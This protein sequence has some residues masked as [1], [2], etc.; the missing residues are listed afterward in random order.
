MH[1]ILNFYEIYYILVLTLQN[2]E[3]I[4]IM[5]MPNKKSLITILMMLV[6]S[7]ATFA[8]IYYLRVKENNK[9]D[10]VAMTEQSFNLLSKTAIE[11]TISS[12]SG[13]FH[14]SGRGDIDFTGSYSFELPSK[15]D[16]RTVITR[17]VTGSNKWVKPP[18]EEKPRQPQTNDVTIRSLVN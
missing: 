14:S 12:K 8:D 10:T 6:L 18:K 17:Y 7:S 2:R 13:T 16:M 9:W 4:K 5:K 11:V 3:E 15:E 1:K